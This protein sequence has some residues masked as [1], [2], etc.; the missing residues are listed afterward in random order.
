MT[1]PFKL[2]K[3]HGYFAKKELGQNF[4]VDPSSPEMII[5]K[6]EIEEG[7]NIVEIGP[8]LG[9]MTMAASK[10]ADFVYG[11]EKDSRLIPLI[12]QEIE[13]YQINNIRI[14]N[15]D[16]LK[17]DIGEYLSEDK[18]NYIIGN[19]PYYI[20]SQIIFL[21]LEHK[22]RI[23]KCVFMLQK[24]LAQ[25][26]VS[27]SG[28]KDYGRI[29]VVL[30]YHSNIKNIASLGPNLFYPKPKVDSSVI[31]IDFNKDIDLKAEDD[32]LFHEVV[33]I[34]FNQRRKTIRNSLGKK[35]RDKKNS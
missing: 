14:I 16:I 4:L 22:K 35:F 19:L 28:S 3:E 6:A 25:R 8:G 24:E 23:E 29:S 30:Q 32:A 9:A 13:K 27:K 21:A 11:I 17:T 18:K 20:S 33:K 31:E 7:S 34:S 2:L 5:R 15:N 12:S 26:I 1:A 10:T